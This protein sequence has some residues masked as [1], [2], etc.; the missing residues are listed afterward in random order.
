MKKIFYSIALLHITIISQAQLSPAI[1]AWLQNITVTGTYY[2]SGNSTALPN[3]ILVNCQ[4]VQYSIDNVYINTKGIP[5]AP[6]RSISVIKQSNTVNKYSN[7]ST[8]CIGWRS[9]IL[10]RC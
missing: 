4:T 5:A 8:G 7:I 9:G 3:N 2:M 6:T 1:T 10:N